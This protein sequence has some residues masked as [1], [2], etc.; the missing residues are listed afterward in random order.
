MTKTKIPLIILTL[1]TL[2]NASHA[3]IMGWL[4]LEGRDWQFI[5]QTGGIRIGVPIDRDG[6]KVL[7]V[8]YDVSGLTTVTRKP[9]TMNSGLAVRKIEAKKK[10]KQIV[11]RVFTQLVEKSSI[12][13]SQH[14]VDLSG[15]PAG[16]YDVFYEVAG[17]KEKILG[18]IEI[19]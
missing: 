15:I 9:T 14:F 19:K 7:P 16:A 5:Q 11:L 8:E 12:T 17:D 3:G 10:D 6:K 1:I 18:Q 4:T 2:A 13:G